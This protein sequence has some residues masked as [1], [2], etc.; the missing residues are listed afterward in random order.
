MGF[1][2]GKEPLPRAL[3]LALGSDF[4]FLPGLHQGFAERP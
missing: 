1:A 4:F 2:L 3:W